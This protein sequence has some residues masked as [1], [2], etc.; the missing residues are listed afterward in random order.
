M[1]GDQDRNNP[2]WK[3]LPSLEEVIPKEEESGTVASP[4]DLSQ[5]T[6]ETR[7]STTKMPPILYTQSF[8]KLGN[9]ERSSCNRACRLSERGGQYGHKGFV[10]YQGTKTIP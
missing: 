3:I 5:M 9:S 1:G 2:S 6:P 10:Y 8:G 7:S 4:P